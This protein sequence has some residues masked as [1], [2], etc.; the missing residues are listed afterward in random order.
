MKTPT[1]SLI[2]PGLNKVPAVT[3]SFWIMSTTVGEAW[4]D[5]PA[6]NASFGQ[7]AESDVPGALNA[8]QWK[9]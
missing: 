7:G 6:V 2:S 8:L 4:V 5:H 3:L 9:A 1:D